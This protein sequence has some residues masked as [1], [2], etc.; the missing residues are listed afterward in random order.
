MAVYTEACVESQFSGVCRF[1][2]L[3]NF[4]A[5]IWQ[6]K[7]ISLVCMTLTLMCIIQAKKPSQK[8]GDS[9]MQNNHKNAYDMMSALTFLAVTAA[10]Q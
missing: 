3:N 4:I 5:F 8:W 7:S 10:H 9:I 6:L 1:K 2:W